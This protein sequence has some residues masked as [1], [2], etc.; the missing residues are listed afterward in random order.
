MKNYSKERKN[1]Y[2]FSSKSIKQHIEHNEF[3]KVIRKKLLEER[4][5]KTFSK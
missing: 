3:I 4:S 2:A 1:G 5:K